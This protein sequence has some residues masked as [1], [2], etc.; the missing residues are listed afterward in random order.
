[1]WTRTVRYGFSFLALPASADNLL[2]HRA[3]FV[4]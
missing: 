1:M 3:H 2:W 4:I